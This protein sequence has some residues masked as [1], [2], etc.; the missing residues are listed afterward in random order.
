M[1]FPIKEP[2]S[3]DSLLKPYVSVVEPAIKG[4]LCKLDVD[5]KLQASADDI[6]A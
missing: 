5:A 4:H 3:F 2:A 1:E 6:E